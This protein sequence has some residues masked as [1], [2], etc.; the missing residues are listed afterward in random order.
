MFNFI[1]NIASLEH[2]KQ[3]NIPRIQ[4][5]HCEERN[6]PLRNGIC[7][8]FFF[9]T[10]E[11]HHFCISFIIEIPKTKKQVEIDSYIYSIYENSLNKTYK[12]YQK[13]LESIVIYVEKT[14]ENIRTE[15]LTNPKTR[16]FFCT[17]Y[18][19]HLENR[20]EEILEEI[21][22]SEKTM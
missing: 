2:I 11:D 14:M 3:L 21:R 13:E 4:Y 1:W 15:I 22:N 17:G 10:E 8:E 12:K 6:I 9:H 7:K 18:T 16:L 19:M 20:M 5:T